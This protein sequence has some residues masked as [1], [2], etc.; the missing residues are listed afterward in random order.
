MRGPLLALLGLNLLV[1]APRAQSIDSQ[2]RR[3][4]EPLADALRGYRRASAEGAD[5]LEAR[6]EVILRLE[7]LAE[8]SGASHPLAA[9]LDLGRALGLSLSPGRERLKP[10]KVETSSHR[11]GCFSVDGIEYA[12]RL[13]EDYDPRTARYPLLVV[14]PEPE[15][16]PADAIREAW[17][18][19]ALREEAIVVAPSMPAEG[20]A[21]SRFSVAGRPGGVPHALTVRRVAAE[22]F[23]VD[24]DRIH[25]AGRGEAVRALLAIAEYGPQNF[26][27]VA[28]WAGEPSEEDAGRLE[29][30]ENL[31]TLFIAGGAV[32]EAFRDRCNQLGHANT[33]LFTSGDC[34][35]VWTWMRGITR[36]ARPE[37]V[38]VDPGDPFPTR[39]YW[40]RISPRAREAQVTA[41]LDRAANTIQLEAEGVSR[42]TLYLD[43][44]LLDLTRPVR[45]ELGGKTIERIVAPDLIT[46]LDLIDDGTSDPGACFT[47]ELVIDLDTG[48]TVGGSPAHPSRDP[49]FL[50]RLEEAGEEIE[51]LWALHQREDAAGRPEHSA[52]ALRRIVRLQ[53]DHT[54]AHLALGHLQEGD[55]WFTRAGAARAHRL[56]TSPDEA[57]ARGFIEHKGAWM[58][59]AD[60][61]RSSKGLRQD[62]ESGRWLGAADRRRLED[63]WLLLDEGWVSPEEAPLVDLGLWP[64]AGQWLPLPEADHRHALP[65]RPW[66]LPGPDVTVLATVDR[67]VAERAREHV[68]AALPDLRRVFGVEPPPPLE[69]LVLRDEEQYDSHAFGSPDGSRRPTSSSRLHRVHSAF[70]A[71]ADFRRVDRRL[72]H[73]AL[74]VCYYDPLIPYGEKYGLHSARLAAGYSFVEALDPSPD[75]VKEAL[76]EGGPGPDFLTE[77]EAEKRLPAWLRHGGP[78]YAER[79]FRDPSVTGEGDPYWA[80]A[81]SL[82]NLAA[83]G[84][85]RGL[86]EVLAFPIDPDA[87][88]DSR[89][90]LI[91]AGLVVAF[92]VDSSCTPVRQ[93]HARFLEQLA[94][95]R[96][97]A[98]DVRELEEALLAHEDDLL[99]FAGL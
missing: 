93:A 14:L 27:S 25:L 1:G 65:V 28:G 88:E 95:G 51:A 5:V 81:W 91:E 99:R 30:L 6:G 40:V 21:W 48:S 47:A 20:D 69:V 31:P 7:E 36:K 71:E 49:E 42:V 79:F 2:Q 74:G 15:Q 46:T 52:V 72:E 98:K 84:G 66:V 13:P 60:R 78:V 61:A 96:L 56:R 55:L 11:G 97:T 89:K 76:S 41:E 44:A 4:L 17:S 85:W 10:G 29:N 87:R 62:P 59:P 92:L 3:N 75:A 64:V 94:S 58:H 22:R 37:R 9:P 23:A 34:D 86:E 77:F 90:L 63:G 73:R 19:S 53:P 38:T 39:A 8:E 80:R 67:E 33:T 26:A 70:L 18:C 57:R 50:E 82:A 45:V 32:A 68:E 16:R 35:E 12:F 83:A 54:A 43:D 24:H